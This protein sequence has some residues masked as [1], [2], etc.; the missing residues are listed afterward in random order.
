MRIILLDIEGTVAPI[1]YVKDV[2]F[3]Y[4]RERLEGFLKEHWNDEDVRQ[5]WKELE[6]RV[7]RSL[8]FEEGVKLLKEWIDKDL[9]EKPLKDLQGL[10]WEEGFLK[11]ELVAP[12]YEDAYRKV[13]EWYKEGKKL[14]IYSS[15]S[16][17]AQKLFFSHTNY[18]DLLQFFSGHFDT[19][20]GSK[21]DPESY[22]RISQTIGV[23]PEEVYFFSDSEEELD[24]ARLAGMNTVRVVREGEV[25]SKHKI[26]RSFDQV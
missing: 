14:Y 17:K 15:G 21:R 22:R 4:S 11:G 7:G 3:P 26:I 13:L 25:L 19:S 9:K 6:A 16:V 5:I 12:I 2:M 18:G 20:V 23:G 24:A 1:S 10:I 8:D